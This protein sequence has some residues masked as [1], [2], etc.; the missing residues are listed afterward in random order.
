MDF[1]GLY[2]YVKLISCMQL[3]KLVDEKYTNGLLP[4]DLDLRRGTVVAS[5]ITLGAKGDSY[6]EYLLK[7]VRCTGGN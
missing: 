4:V 7:Q 6:Y 5:K 2:P 3:A 1:A